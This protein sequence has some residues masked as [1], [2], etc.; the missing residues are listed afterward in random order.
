MISRKKLVQQ[1]GSENELRLREISLK[2]V[3]IIKTRLN[4]SLLYLNNCAGWYSELSENKSADSQKTLASILHEGNFDELSFADLEGIM[5]STDYVVGDASS[6]KSYQQAMQGD[7]N[8]SEIAHYS[9]LNDQVMIGLASPVL[10]STGIPKG[11]LYGLYSRQHFAEIIDSE[12]SDG[13]SFTNIIN[14][15]GDYISI[16]DHVLNVLPFDNYWKNIEAAQFEKEYNRE[17]IR[18]N[19]A[20]GKSGLTL[21]SIAGVTQYAY[22]EPIEISDWY[23]ITKISKETLEENTDKINDLAAGL[24]SKF[25][26]YL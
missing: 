11:V 19:I 21:Y 23:A 14:K 24:T 2:N 16:S 18:K 17:D 22:Y 6:Y 3:N 9:D 13:K 25:F 12:I 4:D 20:G 1:A 7:S 26:H 10:D 5:Y 8:I 15:D